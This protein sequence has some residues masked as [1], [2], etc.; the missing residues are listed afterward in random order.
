GT[1][2]HRTLLCWHRAVERDREPRRPEAPDVA[3][4]MLQ[5]LWL[6]R[7]EGAGKKLV[8]LLNLPS[9]NVRGMSSARTVAG[10][11][12]VIRSTAT[13]TIDVRLVKGITTAMAAERVIDHIRGQGFHV[14]ENDPDAQ[15]RMAH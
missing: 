4:E 14:V 15:T 3:R 13:A 6:G 8:E 9:L 12:N 5:E 11:S 1:C 10:A 7:T 2:H